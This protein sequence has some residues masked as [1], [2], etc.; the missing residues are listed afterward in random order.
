[1]PHRKWVLSGFCNNNMLLSSIS[2]S[3]IQKWTRLT[4]KHYEL[5]SPGFAKLIQVQEES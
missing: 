5:L 3:C 4:L 1:M 2:S